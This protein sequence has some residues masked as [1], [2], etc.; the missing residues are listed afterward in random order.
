M[1]INNVGGAQNINQVQGVEAQKV[2]YQPKVDLNDPVDTVEFSSKT[3]SAKKPKKPLSGVASYFVP[4]LGQ[5]IN[6]D[7]KAAG[8]FFGRHVG[9][10]AIAGIATGIAVAGGPVG[11]IALGA[12]AGIGVLVNGIQSVAHAFNNK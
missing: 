4:G 5:L 6:G 8:K 10:S 2:A 3:E 9:L 11:L 1:E 7:K 12:A